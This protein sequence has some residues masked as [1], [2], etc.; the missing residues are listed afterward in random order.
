MATQ[1]QTGAVRRGSSGKE[2][3]HGGVGLS[4]RVYGSIYSLPVRLPGTDVSSR[5]RKTKRASKRAQKATKLEL[6][7]WRKF[8]VKRK[9]RKK[10][11]Q[12]VTRSRPSPYTAMTPTVTHTRTERDTLCNWLPTWENSAHGWATGH[13]A[14]HTWRPLWEAPKDAVACNAQCG[15]VASAS[16]CRHADD[17]KECCW[18]APA[19]PAAVCSRDNDSPPHDDSLCHCENVSCCRCDAWS[20]VAHSLG[21]RAVTRPELRADHHRYGTFVEGTSHPRVMQPFGRRQQSELHSKRRQTLSELLD[22]AL[23]TPNPSL[24]SCFPASLSLTPTT[25]LCLLYKHLYIDWATIIKII[26]IYKARRT[27]NQKFAVICYH[28]SQRFVCRSPDPLTL[29]Y[30][31]LPLTCQ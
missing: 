19:A 11:E 13:G 4:S 2:R 23:L 9:S 6:K 27:R 31:T 10:E 7:M 5:C 24:L 20:G 30:P 18:A 12:E 17:D 14:G 25:L 28:V 26:I 22:G 8:H 15:D 29:P 16:S 1:P 3:E 21:P